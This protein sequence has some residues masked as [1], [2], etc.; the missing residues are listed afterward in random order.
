MNRSFAKP[1]SNLSGAVI[2]QNGFEPFVSADR[3]ASHVGIE[4]RQVMELTRAGKLPAHPVDPE[5]KRKAWRYKLSEV[6]AM[7]SGSRRAEGEPAAAFGRRDN[8]ELTADGKACRSS[9]GSRGGESKGLQGTFST[10][11]VIQEEEEGVRE[12]S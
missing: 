3:V 10:R 9:R 5:A 8:S 7:I 11:A 6:D 12:I 4:R 2:S 1:E